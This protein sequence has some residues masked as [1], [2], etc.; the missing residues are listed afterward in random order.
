MRF[1]NGQPIL[2]EMTKWGDR[3]HWQFPG[4]YLGADVHGEWLGFP[5]GTI[6]A[7]P[8]FT[9][10]ST[11]D[12]VT[13][14]PRQDWWIATFQAPGIWCSIYTDIAS[15]VTWE[16]SIARAVDLDLDVVRLAPG[17]GPPPGYT[18]AP[19]DPGG[20]YIDDEDEFADHRVA[21]DYPDDVITAAERACVGV[22]DRMTARESPFDRATSARWF[23]SLAGL[24][25]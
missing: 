7:R 21:F 11:V 6:N 10:A 4:R 14:L 12:A 22:R 3:P 1:A 17:V 8:G 15:P 13:L 18:G 23:R 25:G 9:F 20:V 19:V 2:V 16:D 5:I 24:G